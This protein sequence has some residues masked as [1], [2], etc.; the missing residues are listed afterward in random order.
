MTVPCEL[1]SRLLAAHAFGALDPREA[2]R[3]EGH[4]A[5][6]ELCL[7]AYQRLGG[8]PILLDLA[9]TGQIAVEPPPPLLE[10]SVVA[11]MPSP[12]R[13]LKWAGRP[14][15]GSLIGLAAL[16]V[17]ASSAALVSALSAA[18]AIPACASS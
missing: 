15:K 17:V 3:V 14:S 5:E 4:L 10:A 6:C 7:A 1:I 16:G 9:G 2:R 13:R 8:L 11:A 12:R 18:G